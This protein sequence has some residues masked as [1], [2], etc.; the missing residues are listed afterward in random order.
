[1]EDL[2]QQRLKTGMIIGFYTPFKIYKPATWLSAL[3]RLFTGA[4]YNHWALIV[5]NWGVPFVNEAKAKGITTSMAVCA[6]SKKKVVILKPKD[7]F[8]EHNI[9][10]KTNSKLGTTGYDFSSLLFFQLIYQLTG[11]W[12]GRVKKEKA[13]KRMYCTEYVGYVYDMYFPEW[14]K[15]D[16]K[17]IEDHHLLVKVFEGNIQSVI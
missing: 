9:A 13:E 10:R 4:K 17:T 2:K 5:N 6:L 16:P 3:I 15:T 8:P 11:W 14:W 12:I 1:M 7:E